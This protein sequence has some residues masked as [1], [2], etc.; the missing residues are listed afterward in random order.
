M[1]ALLYEPNRVG[2]HVLPQ[3][4]C[5][6]K[7]LV[8]RGNKVTVVGRDSRLSS[9]EGLSSRVRFLE[10]G[11]HPKPSGLPLVARV[12]RRELIHVPQLRRLL[13]LA[14]GLGADLLHI[15]TASRLMI[16]LLLATIARPHIIKRRNFQIYLTFPSRRHF[17]PWPPASLLENVYIRLNRWGLR[18]L[19][20]RGLIDHVFVYDSK[21]SETL[22][23]LVPVKRVRFPIE[24]EFLT[25]MSRSEARLKLGLDETIPVA[26]CFGSM[27]YA[28]G[29]DIL[30]EAASGLR[31]QILVAGE[32]SS[33]VKAKVSRLVSSLRKPTQVSFSDGFVPETELDTYFGGAD[34][35]V[36]PYRAELYEREGG[37]ASAY[38]HAVCARTP[39]VV[40]DS[41]DMGRMV[42]DFGLGLTFQSGDAH[43]LRTALKRML[44][45]DAGWKQQAMTNFESLS[46]QVDW[47]SAE[48]SVYEE[49][50]PRM[51]GT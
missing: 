15:R 40:S 22:E 46:N 33:S 19:K 12:L 6:V 51:S 44:D 4:R 29:L 24:T 11:E 45:M 26:L 7:Y 39:L 20:S 36:F 38:L 48:A 2:G 9:L 34:F 3:L 17:E 30:L 1:H 25:P 16:P 14:Q 18:T 28:K 32:L 8:S 31:L 41:G 50:L 27:T 49:I 37:D 21:T 35:A 5:G 10:L 13:G 47:R 43:S 23:S 42:R